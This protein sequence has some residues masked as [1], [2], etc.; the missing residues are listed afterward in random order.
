MTEL[1]RETVERLLERY[2]SDWGDEDEATLARSWLEKDEEL[3]ACRQALLREGV[4]RDR[5]TAAFSTISKELAVLHE[6]VAVL[7][8]R[9]D[10]GPARGHVPTGLPWP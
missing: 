3:F 2:E 7:R 10:P 4:E 6:A 9:I 5:L 1:T 8:D